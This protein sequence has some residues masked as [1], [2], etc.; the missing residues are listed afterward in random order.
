MTTTQALDIFKKNGAKVD[1]HTVYFTK[2]LVDKALST[3]VDSLE[4][5]RPDGTIYQIGKAAARTM[6]YGTAAR[7]TSLRTESSA[8]P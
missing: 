3:V 6:C 1:G 5:Y 7:P 4:L 2:E 8:S